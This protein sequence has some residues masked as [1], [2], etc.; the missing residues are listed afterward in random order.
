VTQ[1][2]ETFQFSA[3]GE[4]L[5]DFTWSDLA[6]WY[7]EIAKV[8]KGKAAILTEILETILKLWHPF[9]PFVTE[10]IWGLARFDGKL[11][12]AKWPTS[13]QPSPSK[14]EG[15]E[16]GETG[17]VGEFER[18]RLLVTDLRR[19]RQENGVEAGKRVD[20][21]IVGAQH[22]V[23]LQE[24]AAWM[25]RLVHGSITAADAMPEGY[26]VAQSGSATIGLNLAGAVDLEKE[27]AKAAKELEDIEKY[28]ASTEAKLANT[29]FVSKAPEK[30]VGDMK[31]KL[32]EAK[33]KRE[34]LKKRV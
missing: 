20:F 27:K 19:L 30:V 13:P 2:L 1:K 18:S 14:G 4:E 9:M 31:D 32:E 6:D 29:D 12:V 8:E 33:T 25:S 15:V 5:R 24:N 7:L 22:A 28:I 26:V 11:I 23:P 17:E 34:A 10:H 21:V 16:H 3:A